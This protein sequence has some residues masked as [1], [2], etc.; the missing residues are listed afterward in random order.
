HNLVDEYKLLVFPLILGK[1]KRLFP[2]GWQANLEL[3]SSQTFPNG[4][5]SLHYQPRQMD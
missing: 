3:L 5:V 2:D 1:G 4:V